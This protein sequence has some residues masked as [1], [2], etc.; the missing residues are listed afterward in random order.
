MLSAGLSISFSIL[1]FSAAAIMLHELF[2]S[3]IEVMEQLNALSSLTDDDT[4]KSE[5]H[6][7]RHKGK[8]ERK[9][10]SAA[11][12]KLMVTLENELYDIGVEIQAENFVIIWIFSAIVIPLLILFL[13]LGMFIA[14]GTAVFIAMAP[15]IYIKVH[16]SQRRKVLESQLIDAI[17][18]MCNAMK[19]GHSFQSAM[20][21]IA[22]EMKGPVADEFGRVFRETLHGMS[23]EESLKRMVERVGSPELEMLSTAVS[24]QRETGGNMS[25]I[26]SN[27]SGTIQ[28]RVIMRKEVKTRTASGRISGYIVGALPIVILIAMY[29]LNPDYCMPLFTTELGRVMLAAGGVMEITGFIVIQKIITVKY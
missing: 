9:T 16:R 19:A 7:E 4:L 18:I 13:D 12:H 25:E 22:T 26:L 2:K 8:K 11:L 29:V 14:A 5:R 20:N 10:R 27:I 15:I 6:I 28:S 1:V 3:K 17:T 21:S 24:I 23:I